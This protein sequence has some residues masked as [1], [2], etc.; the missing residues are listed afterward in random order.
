MNQKLQTTGFT[1]AEKNKLIQYGLLTVSLVMV[2]IFHFTS[3]PF[4]YHNHP[5][6]TNMDTFLYTQYT[7]AWADGHP[8]QFNAGDPATTGCTSHLYPVLLS[9][10]YVFGF[11]SFALIDLMF[12]MNACFFVISVLLFWQIAKKL[13]EVNHWKYALIYALS[14]H[15]VLTILRLS[16]MGLF[17][18]ATLLLWMFI[19]EKSTIKTSILLFLLPFVRPE[20]ILIIFTISLL[21]TFGQV[22]KKEFL[23]G[24]RSDWIVLCSGL[25]GVLGLVL[26]NY[27]LTQHFAFDSTMGKGLFLGLQPIAFM[28]RFARESMTMYKE[29][30]FGVTTNLRQF[31]YLPFIGGI[32]IIAGFI[33]EMFFK[34]KD[35]SSNK[36]IQ[37]IWILSIL[38]T[39][40][41][42]AVSGFQMMHY[43]RYVLWITP[44]LIFWMIRGI[45]FMKMPVKLNQFIFGLLIVFQLVSLPDFLL[46]HL[47]ASDEMTPLIQEIES[48]PQSLS[49]QK[50]GVRGGS[51]IKYLLPDY[52]VINLSGITAPF[53]RNCDNE[54]MRVKNVQHDPDL[55]FNYFL[56]YNA[57]EENLRDLI[58]DSITVEVPYPKKIPVKIYQMNWSLMQKTGVPTQPYILDFL[59]LNQKTDYVDIAYSEDATKSHLKIQSRYPY[60]RA[61]P[62]LYKS[63]TSHGEIVDAAIGVLGKV[64]MTLDCIPNKDHRF[65]IRSLLKEKL[66]YESLDQQQTLTINTAAVKEIEVLTKSGFHLVV[67]MEPFVKLAQDNIMEWW[68]DIP[69]AYVTKDRVTITIIGDHIAC[70]YWLYYL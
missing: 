5:M 54:V 11:H 26:L 31:Y 45:V 30:L 20:G 16:D 55:Q 64:T 34:N 57:A 70:D 42:I 17:L 50:I 51:G 7:K 13:D 43:D 27:S 44:L 46:I 48:I 35:T 3:I 32:L 1:D 56:T 69:K 33:K 63:E 4:S 67:P 14:G 52:R 28:A 53:F 65:V 9:L 21:I 29:L 36:T 8:Y 22:V 37:I 62:F 66:P 24:K 49:P 12:W 68:V 47:T 38:L 23:F 58:A 10:F 60:A 39:M 61:I 40:M 6:V 2:F 25:F 59:N 19:L 41:M 18:I 15:A